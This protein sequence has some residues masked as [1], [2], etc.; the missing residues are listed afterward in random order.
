MAGSPVPVPLVLHG[1]PRWAGR[2]LLSVPGFSFVRGCACGPWGTLGRGQAPGASGWRG[3][4]SALYFS[5]R[6]SLHIANPF[7]MQ[8][9]DECQ[10][11]HEEADLPAPHTALVKSPAGC[12]K[13]DSP[14]G[15]AAQLASPAALAL[16]FFS[17]ICELQCPVLAF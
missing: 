13:A 7:L 3:L 15:K 2:A 1:A 10:A 11:G 9:G 6:F 12:G 8:M 5:H 16:Y 17:L 14:Q 4:A